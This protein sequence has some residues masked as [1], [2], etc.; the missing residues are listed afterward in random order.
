MVE[1]NSLLNKLRQNRHRTTVPERD[2]ALVKPEPQT[3]PDRENTKPPESD[4]AKISTSEGARTPEIEE[5]TTT[6]NTLDDLKAQ[7]ATYPETQRHSAIVLEKELDQEL[8]RYCKDKGVTVET[9]LE[10]AWQVA[11]EDQVLLQRILEEAER[12]YKS[13]KEAGKLRRLI[14]MLSKQ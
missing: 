7:L 4:P 12:R 8:T 3:K 2:D 1:N 10:A 6:D 5:T 9:F 11:S 14:T 13:R